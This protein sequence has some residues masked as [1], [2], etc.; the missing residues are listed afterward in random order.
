MLNCPDWELL[1]DLNEIQADVL[2]QENKIV[3]IEQFYPHLYNKLPCYN[4]DS[5]CASVP[6]LIE[7]VDD[8]SSVDSL[9]STGNASYLSTLETFQTEVE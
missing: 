6:N 8:D 5:T 2:N 7:V 4:D 9:S 1:P 3:Q